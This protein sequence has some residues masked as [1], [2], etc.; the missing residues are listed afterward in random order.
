MLS[1]IVSGI[2][3]QEMIL[4][5]RRRNSKTESHRANITFYYPMDASRLFAIGPTMM[6]SMQMS[7]MIQLVPKGH[8]KYHIVRGWAK[9]AFIDS[10]GA[11]YLF[12]RYFRNQISE[13]FIFFTH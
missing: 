6:A 3:T 7:V 1:D 11:F 13:L 9:G 8:A 5:I 4:D 10:L 12:F 2:S